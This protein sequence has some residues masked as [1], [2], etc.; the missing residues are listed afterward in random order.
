MS[1]EVKRLVP[2]AERLR[3]E[4]AKRLADMLA[5]VSDADVP[6][7][8]RERLLNAL[9]RITEPARESVVWPGGFTMISREQTALIWDAIRKL[10]PEDRPNQVRHAFDLVLLNLRWDTGEVMLTRDEFAERMGCLPR[11][12][13]TVM[14]VLAR[15][16]VIERE[17]RRVDGMRGRGM[18]VYRINARVAW[19]GTLEVRQ[20]LAESEPPPL[21]RIMEGGKRPALSVVEGGAS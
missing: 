12:V 4:Q 16:G 14:G 1:A 5:G 17:R 8:A 2:R 19:N 11:D 3:R 21:L 13:S 10:P 18:A 7:W 15:M 9:Q 20:E 6:A